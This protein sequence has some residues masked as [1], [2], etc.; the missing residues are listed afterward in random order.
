MERYVFDKETLKMHS[1]LDV[2]WMVS[3]KLEEV[4]WEP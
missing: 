3:I 4:L 2:G 1:H